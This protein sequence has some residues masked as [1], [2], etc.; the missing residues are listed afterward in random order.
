MRFVR[1]LT[2]EPCALSGTFHRIYRII[3]FHGVH[4]G[5]LI[6]LPEGFTREMKQSVTRYF[7]VN[8]DST[9]ASIKT[10]YSEDRRY[11]S[12]G[13][14]AEKNLCWVYGDLGKKDRFEE[15]DTRLINNQFFVSY[16][17]AME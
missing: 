15:M 14:S 13:A 17:T 6:M 3:E 4:Y 2:P 1:F 9:A 11:N 7:T 8:D 12:Q 5:Y 10:V 16:L